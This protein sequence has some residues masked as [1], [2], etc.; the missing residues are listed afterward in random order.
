MFINFIKKLKIIYN[1]YDELQIFIL[2]RE[3]YF[4]VL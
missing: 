4:I 3:K 2:Y 1:I